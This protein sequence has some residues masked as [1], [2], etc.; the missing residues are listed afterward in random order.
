MR[1]LVK[2]APG[3]YTVLL[4]PGAAQLSFQELREA[5]TDSLLK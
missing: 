2:D 4:M 5:L 1:E 3:T